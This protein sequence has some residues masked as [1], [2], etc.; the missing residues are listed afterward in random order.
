MFSKMTPKDIEKA[1]KKALL[2]MDKTVNE[3][4]VRNTL[5]KLTEFGFWKK[6]VFVSINESTARQIVK[7]TLDAIK[8]GPD[9]L[10]NDV[11]NVVHHFKSRD[12]I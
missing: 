2:I 3:W 6:E 8:H 12:T 7:A 1:T 10:I 4:A 11:Y 5:C 9:H